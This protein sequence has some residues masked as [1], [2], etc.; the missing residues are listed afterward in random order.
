MSGDLLA[1]LTTLERLGLGRDKL[2]G[3][4]SLSAVAALTRLQHF[5]ML[6]SLPDM[7]MQGPADTAAVTASSQLTFLDIGSSF[8]RYGQH[9]DLFPAGKQLPNLAELHVNL[10]MVRDGVS[11][12]AVAACCPILQRLKLH[13]NYADWA[14][15]EGEARDAEVHALCAL[16]MSLQPLQSL[17]S[18]EVE[19][20][21]LTLSVPVW[22]ALGCLTQLHKLQVNLD[23]VEH[24]VG[25]LHLTQCCRLTELRVSAL[26]KDAIQGL[27]VH[28]SEQVGTWPGCGL[29]C[30]VYEQGSACIVACAELQPLVCRALLQL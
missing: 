14:V 18:L 19:A 4:S 26:D 29:Y 21:F 24:V 25:V 22:T 23:V 20:G 12:A 2:V 17:T 13:G 28:L 27:G 11:G 3:P 30:I 10:D 6:S 15:E 7:L 16:M 9:V 1:Q 8:R 5:K